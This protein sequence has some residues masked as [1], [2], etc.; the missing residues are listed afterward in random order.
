MNV[1][2]VKALAAQVAGL[3]PVPAV[4]RVT[5]LLKAGEEDTALHL[6]L[7]LNDRYRCAR[8]RNYLGERNCR[9]NDHCP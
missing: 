7:Y 3:Q 4:H 5:A 2:Y 1:P 9:C 8:Q 6:M